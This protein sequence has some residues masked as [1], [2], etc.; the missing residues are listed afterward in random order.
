VQTLLLTA[1]IFWLDQTGQG[2]LTFL[3]IPQLPH[4]LVIILTDIEV[5]AIHAFA[6]FMSYL[7]ASEAR[8]RRDAERLNA[9]LLATQELLEQSSRLAERTFVA[10]ELHDTLG[11]HLVALK[12]QLEL[13]HH[14]ATEG[15]AKV[16]LDD[17]LALVTKLLSDVREVVSRVRTPAT[18]DLRKAVETMLAGI[19]TPSISLSFPVELQINEP[20]LPTFCF[21]AYKRQ[22]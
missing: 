16:P 1:W 7:A 4:V 20:T 8:R 10:R 9:E 15:K 3:Q 5:F 21:G 6:F 2:N 14:L 22:Y 18:I 11:H 12:V 17:A 13:A 19:K